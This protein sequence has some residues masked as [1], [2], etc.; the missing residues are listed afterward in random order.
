MKTIVPLHVRIAGSG[1]PILCVHGHPGSSGCMSVFTAHLSRR[2]RTLAPDLRGYGRSRPPGAFSMDVHLLDLQALLD[3]LEIDRCLILGWSLGG[4]I[5]ME[6]AATQPQRVAGMILLG[7]AARPRGKHP[8]TD[9]ADLLNTGIASAL[10][11]IRPGW[12]WNID[13][14]GKRS[15]YRY[16]MTQQTPAA[17]RFLAAEGTAAYLQT[18]IAAHQALAERNKGYDGRSYLQNIRCPALVLAG[19]DDRHISVESSQETARHLPNAQWQSYPRAAH[20]FPWEIPE[21][22]LDDID[23]WLDRHRHLWHEGRGD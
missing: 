17:Y 18:S 21:R 9:W 16:L 7:T 15:L 3:R 1:F 20:L 23:R 14:F 10:N 4:I 12:Q 5:A 6:L 8:P 13:T 19:E 2:F 22:V 11:W